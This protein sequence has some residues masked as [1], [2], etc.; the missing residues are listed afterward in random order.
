VQAGAPKV[1]VNYV[2]VLCT[3]GTVLDNSFARK[4]TLDANLA[5]GVIPGW[6]QGIP[7]MK[8]GGRR[9]LEIP[10]DLAYGAD[11]KAPDVPPNEPLFFVVDVVAV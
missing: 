3:T 7:G 4:Q 6:Q 1:T 11:G 9:L 5:G 10:P 2:G 8:V